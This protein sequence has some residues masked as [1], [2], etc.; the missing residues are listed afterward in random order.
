M[1][2]EIVSWED[3]KPNQVRNVPSFINR[4]LG[5]L[6]ILLVDTEAPE[7]LNTT[8]VDDGKWARIDFGNP[9]SG[10]ITRSVRGPTGPVGFPLM[11]GDDE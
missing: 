5:K 9:K 10:I 11:K 6:G 1:R 7:I 4:I 3:A 2:F 8:I